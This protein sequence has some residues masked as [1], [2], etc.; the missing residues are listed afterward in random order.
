[1]NNDPDL[2]AVLVDLG[3]IRHWCSQHPFQSPPQSAA[4]YIGANKDVLLFFIS[5]LKSTS[6]TDR[7]T[8]H[9]RHRDLDE[10]V[11]TGDCSLACSAVEEAHQ[12]VTGN[13]LADVTDDD[14]NMILRVIE[15]VKYIDCDPCPHEVRHSPITL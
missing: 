9:S 2:S 14:V 4:E 12:S 6:S 15:Y 13:R 3:R 11:I 5:C 10:S 7:A 1:M 8:L